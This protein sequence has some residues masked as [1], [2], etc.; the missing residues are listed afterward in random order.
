M[1]KFCKTGGSY[2][3]TMKGDPICRKCYATIGV[4][5]HSRWLHDPLYR[6]SADASACAARDERIAEHEQKQKS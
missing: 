3:L 2:T 6:A 1:C 5:E 4:E